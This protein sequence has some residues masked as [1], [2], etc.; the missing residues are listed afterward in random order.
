MFGRFYDYYSPPSRDDNLFRSSIISQLM[1]AL[2][3]PFLLISFF[4][5]LTTQPVTWIWISLLYCFILQFPL[6]YLA[7]AL[8]K[9]RITSPEYLQILENAKRKL[10]VSRT[11]DA[12][13]SKNTGRLL[14]SANTPFQY[15]IMVSERAATLIEEN[16]LEGEIVLAYE[17]AKLRRDKIGIS[18]LRNIGAF[19]YSL[20]FEG[21]VFAELILSILPLLEMIPL[22]IPALVLTYP[23]GFGI[24][25][26]YHLKA[27]AE[28]EVESIYRMNPELAAFRLVV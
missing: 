12:H 19:Y 14:T 2:S 24:A 16:P 27:A 6:Y 21:M 8:R 22:W 7:F 11:V 15:G 18:I 17:L 23:F 25:L 3:I 13:L 4:T 28:N 5:D 26:R 9:T 20:I 1:L 10:Q